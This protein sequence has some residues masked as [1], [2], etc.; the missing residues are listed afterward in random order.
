VCVCVC[1]FVACG[2]VR[3]CVRGVQAE[4]LPQLDR[5]QLMHGS[6]YVCFLGVGEHVPTFSEMRMRE[7]DMSLSQRMP[8]SRTLATNESRTHSVCAEMRKREKDM[9]LFPRG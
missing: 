4:V 2:C 8:H 6:V 9:S 5:C 7:K 3:A 1:V